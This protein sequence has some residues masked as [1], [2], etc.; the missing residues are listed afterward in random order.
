MINSKLIGEYTY[1]K[2]EKKNIIYRDDLDIR[3]KISRAKFEIIDLKYKPNDLCIL[4]DDQLL[5]ANSETKSLYVYDGNFNLIKTINKIDNKP[6]TPLRLTTNNQN[7]IY[8]T[9]NERHQVLMVDYLFNKIKIIGSKGNKFNQF[10]S[11]DGIY[12]KAENVFVCDKENKRIQKF[13]YDLQYIKSLSL[14]YIP[15]QVR[16]S[17]TTI[18]VAA[19]D[20]PGLYAYELDTFDLKYYYNHGYSRINEINLFFYECVSCSSYNTIYCYNQNGN[21]I[22]ELDVNILENYLISMED[23][24]LTYF[25]KTLIITS[26]NKSKLIKF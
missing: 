8:I 21:L 18:F 15:L 11:P 17:N 6:F 23:G 14:D 26:C 12:Y 4:S 3:R 1:K 24:A 19:F 10:S 16:V 2:N 22:E 7:F 25:N 13:S 9:D 20:I 5:I